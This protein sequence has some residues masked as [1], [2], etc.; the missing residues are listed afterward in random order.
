MKLLPDENLH[1]SIKQYLAEHDVYTAQEMGWASKKNGELLQLMITHGF[2]VLITADK[3]MRHQQN[4]HQQNVSVILLSVKSLALENFLPLVPKLR[5]L[6]TRKLIAG[7]T[8][9]E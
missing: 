1:R 7:V 5:E 8:V 3:N 9:V 2:H 4:F 6:L